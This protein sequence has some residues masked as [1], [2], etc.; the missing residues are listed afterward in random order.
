MREILFCTKRINPFS[1]P[2]KGIADEIRAEVW[3]YLLGLDIWEHTTAEREERRKIKYEEYSQMK[4][5]WQTFSRV[6]ERNFCD[7]KQRREEIEFYVKH[8]DTAY[9]FFQ[10]VNNPNVQ[11][12]RNILV[13]YVMYNFDLGFGL[14]MNELLAP[15]L[16][17][18][19]DEAD[20]FWCFAGFVEK[21]A[22]NFDFS[23]TEMKQQRE[24][25]R[26]LVSFVNE[27]LHS[28]LKQQH[29]QNMIF[30]YRYLHIWFKN[31]F[32]YPDIMQLWEV[33]WTGLPCPN[34]YLF[35]CLAILDQ[36]TDAIIEG[37]FQFAE[38]VNHVLGL[39]GKL[40]LT[41]ILEQAEAIY[42]QVKKTLDS[43]GGQYPEVRRI[44]GEV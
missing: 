39:S 4:Q 30:C 28:F 17:A 13:T 12:M 26:L 36:E 34:F 29:S 22:D 6:Q 32:S 9:E 2:F 33:L 11:K 19:R 38:L 8:T 35:V 24:E 37:Q 20:T 3:K 41:A 43:S 14:G 21:V 44:I 42:L 23:K 27:K 25:L 40:N 5:Q 15:M 31:E 18:V 1:S 16:C 10:G 7:F